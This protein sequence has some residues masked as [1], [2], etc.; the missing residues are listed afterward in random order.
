MVSGSHV[1]VPVAAGYRAFRVPAASRLISA[2]GIR[3]FQ[4]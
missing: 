2:A 4:F 1:T 3:A